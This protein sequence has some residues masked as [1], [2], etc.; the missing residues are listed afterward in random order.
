MISFGLKTINYNENFYNLTT[1]ESI[2]EMK[3]MV[4]ANIDN[5]DRLDMN[6]GDMFTNYILFFLFIFLMPV[7]LINL[8]IGVS[9]G[10]LE[11]VLKSAEIIQYE[12]RVV[13]TL[14]MQELLISKLGFRCCEK[15][16]LFNEYRNR[17]VEFKKNNRKE[18]E[19]EMMD[20]FGEIKNELKSHSD[21][22]RCS[23]EQTRQEMIAKMSEQNDKFQ[24]IQE[25]TLERI[26]QND[27][28]MERQVKEL[29]E[30]FLRQ[31]DSLV[32]DLMNKT[33]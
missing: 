27:K 32:L 7:L 26:N 22:L 3:S 31:F 6:T 20:S 2:A 30:H 11:E 15:Y 18:A 13:F 28:K 1:L 16:F 12:M 25:G 21:M 4:L 10:Q 17:K 8:L 23:L 9:T 14:T 33:N 19:T 29:E 24:T 5:L